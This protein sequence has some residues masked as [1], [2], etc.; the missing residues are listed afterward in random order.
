MLLGVSSATNWECA[1]D[2]RTVIFSTPTPLKGTCRWSD[3]YFGV[4]GQGLPH[5]LQFRTGSQDRM[6]ETMQSFGQGFFGRNAE[7]QYSLE[8]EIESPAVNSTECRSGQKW[9]LSCGVL[10]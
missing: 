1:L 6:V 10:N 9:G 8:I 2:S 3:R 7:D 5:H 4:A